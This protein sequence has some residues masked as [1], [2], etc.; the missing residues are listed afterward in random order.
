MY[1]ERVPKIV[2][3]LCGPRAHEATWS[4]LLLDHVTLESLGPEPMRHQEAWA[5]LTQGTPCPAETHIRTILMRH[6]T[7]CYGF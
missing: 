7:T 6:Y 2:Y 4:L 5:H 1:R 3:S